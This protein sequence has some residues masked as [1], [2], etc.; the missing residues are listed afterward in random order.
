MQKQLEMILESDCWQ[1]FF[2]KK[3]RVMGI[4]TVEKNFLNEQFYID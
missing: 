2:K 4:Y 3:I 1:Y